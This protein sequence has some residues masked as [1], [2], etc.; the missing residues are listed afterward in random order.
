MKNQKKREMQLKSKCMIV[1][2]SLWNGFCL[3]FFICLFVDLQFKKKKK[4]MCLSLTYELTINK[5]CL[6]KKYMCNLVLKVFSNLTKY[7]FEYW[8]NYV[9]SRWH[10]FSLYPMYLTKFLTLPC[11]GRYACKQ[12]AQGIPAT[13]TSLL[14]FLVD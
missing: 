2:Y 12:L 1:E 9:R 14:S 8:N 7:W 3:I 11:V 6:F 5:I 10:N 13:S 4:G